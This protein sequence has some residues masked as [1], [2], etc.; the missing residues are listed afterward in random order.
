MVLTYLALFTLPLVTVIFVGQ[1]MTRTDLAESY[2]L[3]F[4]ASSSTS[5]SLTSSTGT[6]SS[7]IQRHRMQRDDWTSLGSGYIECRCVRCETIRGLV[8]TSGS[9][10]SGVFRG[11]SVRRGVMVMWNQILTSYFE[12]RG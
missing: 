3:F 9:L 2:L 12:T 1:R 10:S 5:N 7:H 6:R 4:A 11:I 8:V